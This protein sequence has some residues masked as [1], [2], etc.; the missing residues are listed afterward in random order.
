MVGILGPLVGGFLLLTVLGLAVLA[1]LRRTGSRQVWLPAAPLLGAALTAVVLS[2]TSW[3]LPVR[4][5]VLVVIG[6]AIGAVVL[7]VVRKSRFWVF[8]RGNIVVAVACWL[9]GGV[10]AM[11]ALIPNL[12]VGD[13]RVISANSSH[14][15]FYYAAESSWLRDYAMLPGPGI[16]STPALSD[17]VPTYGPGSR[18]L[19]PSAA[20]GPADGGSA[21]TVVLGR[22]ELSTTM[23]IIAL[24]VMLVSGAAFVAGRL[25]RLRIAAASDSRSPL[26]RPALLINQAYSQN[27]DSLLGIS[28]AVCTVGAVI[29]AA[30]G[31]SPRWPAASCWPVWLRSSRIRSIRRPGGHRRGAAASIAPIPHH[32]R[33][34][35]ASAA[36]RCADRANRMVAR[37]HVD[38]CRA[39]RRIRRGAFA[40]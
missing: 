23:P 15:A 4:W 6:V 28:F 39:D 10:A 33:P 27:A 32:R 31:R 16:E 36:D 7:A 8:S 37:D 12:M 38:S 26:C 19:L 17:L 11:V 21:I 24:W 3:V 18:V 34:G 22:D 35:I 30:Q 5:G 1:P 20:D 2:A 40:V 14:D 9:I 29:A 13:A 25:L